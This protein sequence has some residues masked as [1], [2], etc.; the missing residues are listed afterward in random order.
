MQLELHCLYQIGALTLRFDVGQFEILEQD[1]EIRIFKEIIQ[2]NRFNKLADVPVSAP[3]LAAEL[4]EAVADEEVR[5]AMGSLA[6]LLNCVIDRHLALLEIFERT[7]QH[8]Q[9]FLRK[10]QL[11]KLKCVANDLKINLA[12]LVD[13]T[14]VPPAYLHPWAH[15]QTVYQLYRSLY[16][17][18]VGDTASHIQAVFELLSSPRVPERD[19]ND[20][21]AILFRD[22]AKHPETFKIKHHRPLVQLS[23]VDIQAV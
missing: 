14:L 10:I 13:I 9:A 1:V 12:Q 11:L 7:R 19:R 3:E 20:I 4:R 5:G 17:R 6:E 18:N 8:A 23:D 15:V 21:L 22:D 16:H 2:S